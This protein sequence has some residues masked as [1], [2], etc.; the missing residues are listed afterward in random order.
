MLG[1]WHVRTFA[2]FPAP[3][4]RTI[5]QIHSLSSFA[6]ACPE[7][8]HCTTWRR[9]AGSAPPTPQLDPNAGSDSSSV[10]IPHQ[11]SGAINSARR[12]TVTQV[13]LAVRTMDPSISLH[14]SVLIHGSVFMG[15]FENGPM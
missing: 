7:G 3:S 2:G 14:G 15:P 12:H 6:R 8:R 9:K 13:P 1:Q 4:W 5:A 10:G 11:S